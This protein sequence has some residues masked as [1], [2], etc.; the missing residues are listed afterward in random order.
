[1][2]RMQART[3]VG[4]LM[5]ARDSAAAARDRSD[6]LFYSKSNMRSIDEADE[7]VRQGHYVVKTMEELEAMANA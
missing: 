2:E 3:N 6:D 4:K 7:R 1:M 5:M